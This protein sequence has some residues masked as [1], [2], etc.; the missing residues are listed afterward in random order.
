MTGVDWL[1]ICLNCVEG[2][3]VLEQEGGSFM[4][5]FYIPAGYYIDLALWRK[6]ERQRIR[7]REGQ[8]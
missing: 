5:A 7:A 2:G 6:R 3:F 1:T 8:K 4:L